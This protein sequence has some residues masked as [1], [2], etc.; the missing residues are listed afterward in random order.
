MKILNSN[1]NQIIDFSNKKHVNIYVCG[2]TVYDYTHIGNIRPL[3]LI[4]TIIRILKYKKIP[5][6]FVQ[7][8]T[9]VDDKI[10]KKAIQLKTTEKLLT[11]KYYNGYIND[12]ESLNINM[13][14]KII[15]VTDIIKENIIFI[16]DLIRQ[17]DAYPADG[18]VYFKIQRYINKEKNFYGELSN[19]KLE[20]LINYKAIQENN[21]KKNYIDFAIWKKTHQG[22]KWTSP[23]GD[24]RPGWHTECAVIN[25]M[26]FGKEGA[27]I[28]LGGIDLKFPHNENERI[29]YI[30]KHGKDLS[31]LWLYNGHVNLNKEKMS[32]SLGNIINTFD[33][34]NTYSQNI[35]RWIY[36]KQKYSQPIFLTSIIIQQANIEVQK[37]E[38]FIKNLRI[39]K[40]DHK[41]KNS[42]FKDNY[43]EKIVD[44]ISDNVNTT[45]A[46]DEVINFLKYLNKQLYKKSLK[47]EAVDQFI[48]ILVELFG[49]KINTNDLNKEEVELYKLWKDLLKNKKYE[50][51]DKIRTSLIKRHII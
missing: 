34:I 11:T 30:A 3:I 17:G 12:L 24:G 42:H 38:Q 40:I 50:S 1:N 46:C 7:N 14:H 51:A 41:I 48:K 45:A 19:R 10:I 5:Y 9:D 16:N 35:L 15:K 23:W 27:D 29:Q 26:V 2:P 28:H 22:V 21:N 31:K 6:T 39:Y 13:P 25:D 4:D 44:L 20:D 37:I 43:F 32:K 8:I 18:D 36:L 47:K 33:F 49:F